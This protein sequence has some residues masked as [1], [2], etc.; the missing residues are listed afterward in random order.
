MMSIKEHR[1][2]CLINVGAGYHIMER[3]KKM[4]TDNNILSGRSQII[5]FGTIILAL[6]LAGSAAAQNIDVVYD[7][8]VAQQW[9][10]GT[11]WCELSGPSLYNVN[12]SAVVHNGTHA[13][14]INHSTPA[15]TP[16]SWTAFELLRIGEYW[17]PIYWMYPNQYKNISFYFNPGQ[18]LDNLDNLHITAD[19]GYDFLLTDYIN[20]TVTPDTWYHVNIP[21]E[22]LN[23]G[24][25]FFRIAFFFSS[26][27]KLHYYLDDISL[28]WIDDPN[29]PVIS[30]VTVTNITWKSAQ[31]TWQTDEYTNSTL[32]Y[33]IGENYSSIDV[34]DYNKDNT[35]LLINLSANTTY[36]FEIISRDNQVNASTP[37][38]IANY[39]GEF[40]T[41]PPDIV[42]PVISNVSVTN[43]R[44]EYATIFW[45]T[46]EPA[47]SRVYYGKN[48]YSSNKSDDSLS[49]SHR[50]VIT[51]LRL[52]NSYQFKVASRDESGNLAVY[53]ENPPMN[54]T[55]SAYPTAALSVDAAIKTHPFSR[56]ILGSGLGNWAFWWGRPYPNDS[57]KLR[58]LTKLIKPGVLRYAGGLA[59]N[60]VTWD[61][62][63]TQH[64]AAGFY[65]EDGELVW[66]QRQ[67][68]TPGEPLT[69]GY[70]RCNGSSPIMVENA[71]NKGYQKDE[72]DAL[73]AFAKYV[74]A[75][76]MIEVNINTCDPDLWA[77]MLKYTNVENNYNFK[78]WELGNELDL[79]NKPDSGSS[80]DPATPI[81]PEYVSRYK[82]YYA[83]LKAVDND[84]S[85]VGPTTAAHDNDTFWRA[86][87]DY[88]DP[89]TLDPQIQQNKSLDVLSYHNYPLWNHVGGVKSYEDMF[90]F[91]LRE[92]MDYCP[93]EK[94]ELLDNRNLTNTSIA[95]SEFNSM[96]ADLATSYTFN[97]ANA[98]YMA[99]TLARQA[100][101][102]ADMVMHWELYDQTYSN[103]R[104]DTG[105]GLL[106]H[107]GSS[108]SIGYPPSREITIEDKFFPMPVYYTYFMYAQLFGDML[109]ESSSSMEDKLSIWASTDSADPNTLKLMVVNLADESIN[110]SLGLN[111]SHVSGGRY[112]ELSNMDF[113]TAADKASVWD[114]TTINGLEINSSSAQS[115]I[116][117]AKNIIDS[118][119]PISNP[120]NSLNHVFPAYSATVFILN[121][122]PPSVTNATA[123]HEIPDD[124]DNQP[125]WGETA[126]LNVTVV[127]DTANVNV[128]VNLSRIGGSSAQPM[129]NIEGNIYSTTTNASAGTPPG[130]YS[131]TV[132]ATN[133][134]GNS[135]TSVTIQLRVM[136]NGDC[137]GNNIVNIGDALRLANNVSYPWNPLYALSSPY[138]CEVTGNGIINIGDALRLANNVSYPG[139][140]AYELK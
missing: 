15:C 14:E 62:N 103:G 63:N 120:G 140:L 31:I 137:T 50:I 24:N 4:L 70:D 81:G 53:E 68:Y 124:T 22:D 72:I 43:I 111:V 138:V 76:V 1:W 56:N 30:N 44:S 133:I 89:L 85:I 106:N 131:L 135:N 118:G 29:P 71:Y 61:R 107:N 112:Y 49:M 3:W 83:S 12:Q 104:L 6:L 26:S 47:D 46:D 42:P 126:Q 79:A 77:D 119:I 75:D 33:G 51:G 74:G 97:H 65:E 21:L 121:T 66:G 27:G 36:H 32:V 52:Q 59:S 84:I 94:R 16:A 69:I 9:T 82:K 80:Y 10:P 129:E 139:N 7:D 40:T 48:N 18:S 39:S 115:I 98:L 25:K 93:K 136:R 23:R 122:T 5:V 19:N 102:G 35:I 20:E 38:N 100:N 132:N 67:F 128:T 58:E 88:I 95:V 127:D 73:A 45:T 55:T 90:D 92:H 28:D 34:Q 99:D 54:F 37:Q 60:K 2:L 123:S 116:D 109:V 91:S 78:Y 125:R 110:T 8:K 13:I 96:A 113:V 64:Y 130:L 108:I 86:Y 117:S 101:S 105:T 57:L 17:T 134:Y 11:W 87:I 41:A 114:G